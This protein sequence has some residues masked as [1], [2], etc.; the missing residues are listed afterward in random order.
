[1]A[2]KVLTDLAV[3][4]A[5]PGATRREIPDAGQRGLYL[6]VQTNGS[7]S[8]A[9]R[10]RFNGK[11]RKLTL[12][13]GLSLA[14]ARKL[15]A[16]AKFKVAQGIDPIREKEAERER[17]IL[18]DANTVQ[19]VCE[20]YMAIEGKKLRSSA[21]RESFLRRLVYPAIGHRPI[22]ELER[23]EITA[24]LDKV[25]IVKKTESRKKSGGER[26]ADMILAILRKIFNWH[27]TRTSK[28]RS[29]I[30]RGM[31]RVNPR[32]RARD[33]ILTD[34][35][36]RK[37]WE[38]CGDP[39]LAMHGPC[40]RFA[41]LTGARRN[42]ATGL[43]RSEITTMRSDD[44]GIDFVV[45]KLP[46]ARSKS[47]KEVIRPLSKAALEIVESIPVIVGNTD[48][49]FTAA[50]GNG[51]IFLNN[52]KEVLDEISG[53]ADWRI[54]DL[55]RTARTLMSKKALHISS[56][57]AELC[58]GHVLP[59]GLVRGTYDQHRYLDEKAEAFDRL[60]AEI[61][62]IVR[63]DEGGKVIRPAFGR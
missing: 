59:G 30:V 42:E 23:D 1:M 12:E 26:S 16:D 60:A 10:Y 38:A 56:D 13:A 47:K 28:F 33:R 24:L 55:R 21:A 7:K 53:V 19:A 58:L 32:D 17:A 15:A 36:I 48:F 63:G 34:E 45:W 37:I 8:W 41:L 43:R 39:C 9:V 50:T 44:T 2:K 18:A 14:A 29:P 6:I 20:N 25:A 46:A 11:A 35:E 57:V 27:E 4:N 54:H 31:A 62:R 51:P 61:E 3:R 22:G 52:A 40:V 5:K 49:V